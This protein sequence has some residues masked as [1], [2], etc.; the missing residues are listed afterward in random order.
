[1]QKLNMTVPEGT[2]DLLYREVELYDRIAADFEGVYTQRGF[3]RICT[4][5]VENY[6]LFTA[7]NRSLQQENIYKLTDNT[8]RLLAIRPDNTTPIARVVATKLK[9]APLPQKLCYNQH[10]YRVNSENSGMRNEILQSGI[11]LVGAGG[12]KSDLLCITT[13]LDALKTI[14]LNF[15][16]E[17]GHVG[18]FNALISQMDLSDDEVMDVRSFVEAKNFV[19]LNMF[20]KNLQN[21]VIRKLPL[22]YGNEE[23]FEKAEA[24]AGE[25]ANAI[26]ALNYVREL[27]S[28]LCGA[29][30][31]E[32]IMVDMSMVHKFDYY[33]GTVI[34]GYID[35]AG[36]PVLKGGRYDKLLEKFGYDVP[37]TGF[38]INV[39]T[40]A[41]ALIKSGKL[42]NERRSDAVIFYSVDALNEAIKLKNDYSARGL[43]CELSVFDTLAETEAYAKA[44]NIREVIDL[45]NGKDGG[46]A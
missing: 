43:A 20:D 45:T 25:N 7:V 13:A 36:E 17:I 8:G 16:L 9:N 39:C 37:A 4:P 46:R 21:D 44:M 26:A 19:S 28:A 2:R 24:L 18:Y 41:D 10:I 5:A 35:H 42:P 23:V 32:Y 12:I 14:G 1:M 33:T 31:G 15:K 22:L 6:D 40:V 3:S 29:G 38:A 30:Y 34:R 11:E 27:Y